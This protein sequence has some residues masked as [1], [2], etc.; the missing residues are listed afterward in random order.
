MG[1]HYHKL[2]SLATI[3]YK[4]NDDDDDLTVIG[5]RIKMFFRGLTYAVITAAVCCKSS[6]LQVFLFSR[7]DA[8]GDNKKASGV[9]MYIP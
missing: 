3:A 2:E 4:I 7:N 9:Y 8:V 1:S 5:R 6:V